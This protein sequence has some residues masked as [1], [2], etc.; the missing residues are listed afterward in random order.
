MN[1]EITGLSRRSSAGSDSPR[2][3]DRMRAVGSPGQR[4]LPWSILAGLDIAD[5][6]DPALHHR[7]VLLHLSETEVGSD[8]WWSSSIVR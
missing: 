3:G 2:A 6:G 1:Q 5:A 7:A 8:D 4:E